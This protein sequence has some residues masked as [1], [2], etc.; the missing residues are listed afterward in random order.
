MTKPENRLSRFTS[1]RLMIVIQVFSF[2]LVIITGFFALEIG[3]AELNR[4]LRSEFFYTFQ[5]QFQRLLS[6]SREKNRPV[7]IEGEMPISRVKVALNKM[8]LTV[9]ICGLVAFFSGIGVNFTI[10]RG[11]K[12]L[13]R[14]FGS[15]ARGDFTRGLDPHSQ[16]EIGQVAKAYNRMLS[17]VSRYM[18][19][20]STGATFTIN[21]DG[22]ITGFNP[23]AEIIFRRDYRDVVG[24]HFTE[25]FPITRKNRELIRII[26]K[27]IEAQEPCAR[28]DVVMAT[29]ETE[30]KATKV[31]TSILTGDTGK[32]V[33]VVANFGDFEQ[34]KEMQSQM[35]RMNRLASLGGLVA[36]LAHEIRT[37][38]GS[39]K[40]FAQLLAE[41]LPEEDRKRRYADILVKEIDRLNRVA[42]ELLSLAQ[43]TQ[44]DFEARDINQIIRE[45]VNLVK[46]NFRDRTIEVV[47]R[48]DPN[49]PKVVV[50]R[51]RLVQAVLN[52][53]TN[54]FE[55]TPDQGRIVVE[56]HRGNGGEPSARETSPPR[57]IIID[58][59]NTGPAI[60]F[61]EA[62]RMFDPFFTT[63]DRGTG[64]GLTIAQQVAVAHG[65]SLTLIR[66][67]EADQQG[68]ITLRMELPA[69]A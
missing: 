55:A 34:V 28:E 2:L 51:N 43:P 54:A 29:S 3:S 63:K 40:G 31:T 32:L 47:E 11:L 48:Y 65:G 23:M 12:K 67:P 53:L 10:R 8:R 9:L 38:L 33:E 62:E 17:S 57:S 30:K 25:L 44:A 46:A 7:P 60:P 26:M 41:D 52:I 49:L 24:G 1:V 5:G 13:T 15:V 19:D 6:P 64:L 42:D 58:F 4:S 39:L 20:T 59:S 69:K 21:R 22:I 50:E 45:A 27:G 61:K 66:E 36:G 37:P 56:T 68:G 16:E 14:S 35:E 18:L